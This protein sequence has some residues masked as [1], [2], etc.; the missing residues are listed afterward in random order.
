M[1]AAVA[2][3]ADA[4]ITRL[5]LAQFFLTHSHVAVGGDV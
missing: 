4:A 3:V 5:H 2:A 1:I